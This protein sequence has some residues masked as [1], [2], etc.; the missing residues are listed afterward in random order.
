LSQLPAN[1][2]KLT[3]NMFIQFACD[4][5]QF[6]HDDSPYWLGAAKCGKDT[7]FQGSSSTL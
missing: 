3:G 1:L 7:G 6:R 5:Y 4:D 2:K